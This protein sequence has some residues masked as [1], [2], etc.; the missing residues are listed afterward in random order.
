MVANTEFQTCQQ[1]IGNKKKILQNKGCWVIRLLAEKAL[2][3]NA[4]ERASMQ[5]T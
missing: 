3:L 1:I 2:L 5:I 4:A